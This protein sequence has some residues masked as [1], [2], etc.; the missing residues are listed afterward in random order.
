MIGLMRMVNG[1]HFGINQTQINWNF[2]MGNPVIYFFIG[3]LILI[4]FMQI[5]NG[6][7]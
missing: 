5:R 7:K 6:W 1:S 2:S 3:A 4:L